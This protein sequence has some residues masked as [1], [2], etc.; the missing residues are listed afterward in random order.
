MAIAVV[1]PVVQAQQAGEP[2]DY[3]HHHGRAFLLSIPKSMAYRQ[4]I[5][6]K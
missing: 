6:P 3:R 1:V 4:K 2:S 5:M